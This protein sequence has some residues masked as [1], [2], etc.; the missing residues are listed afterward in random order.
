MND[1]EINYESWD[2]E[3]E[4][5]ITNS[6]YMNSGQHLTFYENTSEEKVNISE[7]G[8]KLSG[9]ADITID[10]KSMKEFMQSIEERLLILQDDFEKHEMYPALKDAYEKYKLIEKL[11]RNK[12]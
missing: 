5:T 12:G 6:T 3:H 1:D 4:A 7:E 8:V 11:M 2:L 9:D 10:G